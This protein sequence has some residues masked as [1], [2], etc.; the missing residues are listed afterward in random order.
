LVLDILLE[1][2]V[3][4]GTAA[5]TAGA[6][7]GLFYADWFEGDNFVGDETGPRQSLFIQGV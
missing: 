1:A 7:G 6:D 5:E 3:E 4:E 2:V